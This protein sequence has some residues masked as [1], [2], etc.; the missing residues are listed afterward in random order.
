MTSLLA[1]NLTSV[2]DL[3]KRR[4]NQKSQGFAGQEEKT[5]PSLSAYASISSFS[6]SMLYLH[7]LTALHKAGILTDDEYTAAQQRI[8]GS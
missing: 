7:H 2:G 3:I 4:Q 8:L 5:V 1:R 6:E